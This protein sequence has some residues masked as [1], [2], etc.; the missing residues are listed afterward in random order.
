MLSWLVGVAAGEALVMAEVEVGLGTVIGDEDLA[1][2]VGAHGARVDVQIG[3]ELAEPD[4]EAPRLQQRTQ[5]RRCQ[6]LAERGDHAAGDED[7]S[8][9][10]TLPYR[11]HVMI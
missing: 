7:V 6:T 8:R 4:R 11:L 10:G 9:H 2:L 5:C 1:V 3:I